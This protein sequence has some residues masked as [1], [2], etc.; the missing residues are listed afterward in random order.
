MP[1][2]LALLGELGVRLADDLGHPFRGIRYVS[3][4][5]VT[6]AA[7]FPVGPG[8]GIRRTALSAALLARA[9]ELESIVL[10]FG[11][12][13]E[14][15]VE[16]DRVALRV[17]NERLTAPLIVG[18]DGLHSKLRA[19]AVQASSS[20]RYW[21]WGMRQHFAVEPWS[22]YVDVHWGPGIEAY[23]T[24]VAAREV[25]LAFLWHRGLRGPASSTVSFPWL[26]SFFPAV[27]ARLAGA[28]PT[29]AVAS[30]GPLEQRVSRPTGDG[31][32]LIGDASGYLD[33]I[34]GEGLSLAFAQA[35]ALEHIAARLAGATAPL[36][37]ADLGDYA[38]A[39]RRITAPY[40]RMTSLVLLL[41]RHGW[42]ADPAIRVLRASP[43]LFEHLLMANMGLVPITRFWRH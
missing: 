6:A 5:G 7:D 12:P 4:S 10:R 9:S 13:A 16:S 17:G 24:P 3:R 31:V 43:K 14:L 1:N 39:V 15:E 23:V 22:E 36:T 40:K 32:A 29:S 8:R 41:S 21:R 28:T 37:A 20:R 2:G 26:L 18:A 30:I 33:A 25:G 19:V 38:D 35:V 27:A 34:T 11:T 42:L